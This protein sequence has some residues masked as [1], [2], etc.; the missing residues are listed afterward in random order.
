MGTAS[1]HGG[2][3]QDA[4]R[5][6]PRNS[7]VNFSGDDVLVAAGKVAK[8]QLVRPLCETQRGFCSR[9]DELRRLQT[10][11]LD[12]LVEIIHHSLI[13]AVKLSAS[14]LVKS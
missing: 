8:K 1:L 4:C 12:E 10:N 13:E 9:Y 14:L 11:G 5:C 3:F 7:D 6:R 2:K